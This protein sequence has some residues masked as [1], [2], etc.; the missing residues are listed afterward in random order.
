MV[1]A[2]SNNVL[3]VQDAWTS[4]PSSDRDRLQNAT[5]M[6]AKTNVLPKLAIA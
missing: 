1:G 2:L 4:S 3:E 5:M 6:H